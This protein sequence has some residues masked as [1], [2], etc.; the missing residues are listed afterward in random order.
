MTTVEIDNIFHQIEKSVHKC[1][2]YFNTIYMTEKLLR[3]LEAHIRNLYITQGGERIL[4]GYPIRTYNG[5]N[6]EFKLI[7]EIEVEDNIIEVE[8]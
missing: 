4:F 8:G 1:Y 6:Y 2:G 5:E 7:R 3:I